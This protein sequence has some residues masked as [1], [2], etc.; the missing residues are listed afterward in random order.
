[1]E[2]SGTLSGL[3]IFQPAAIGHDL[4]GGDRHNRVDGAHTSAAQGTSEPAARP[5]L[6]TSCL[7]NNYNYA[8]FVGDAVD[9]ALAQTAAFDEIIVVDDG[10]TDDSVQMLTRRYGREERVRVVR[11]PN[12]GQ[13]SSF[14]EGFLA[15][16]GDLVFFLDADDVYQPEYVETM[17][18]FYR[19]RPQYDFV[20]C[21][22]RLFGKEEREEFRYPTDVDF[23]HTMALTYFDMPWIGNPTSCISARRELLQRF[24][25][26]QNTYDWRIRADDCLLFGAALAGGRKFFLRR[27]LVRY[28]VHG[29]NGFYGRG[30]EAVR[31]YPR[32]LTLERLRGEICD[33]LGLTSEGVARQISREF[34][35]IPQPTWKQLRHYLRIVCRVAPTR[36]ARRQML[37]EIVA[38]HRQHSPDLRRWTDY[39]RLWGTHL[40]WRYT[41]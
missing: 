15:S 7:I 9:S 16:S 41:A 22:P 20:F 5:R 35:T 11:K 23:G 39:V 2:A 28:R 8:H 10:S 21:A 29:N 13:L 26:L 18:R 32:V 1:M 34:R 4:P 33:R 36:L 37:A 38:H 17:L 27:C 40:H 24:L 14:N 30:L 3:D 31:D 6:K 19:E 25:P 12:G